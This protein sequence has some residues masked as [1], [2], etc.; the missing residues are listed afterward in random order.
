METYG[1]AYRIKFI[2]KDAELAEDDGELFGFVVQDKVVCS[3]CGA[4]I[5]LEE[6]D[7]LEEYDW[8]DIQDA[9]KG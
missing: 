7:I 1:D 6:V 9:I 5:P 8:F 3:C 4:I 2:E